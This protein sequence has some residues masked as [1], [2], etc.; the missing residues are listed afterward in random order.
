MRKGGESEPRNKGLMKM[1]NL[2]NIGERAESG[3]PYIFN[4][5]EQEGWVEPIEDRYG[6]ASRTS[7]VLSFQNK[8]AISS[9]MEDEITP[10][11][12]KEFKNGYNKIRFIRFKLYISIE[13]K[14]GDGS[15]G[16]ENM[17]AKYQAEDLIEN[18]P[19]LFK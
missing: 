7:L 10:F 17:D 14:S 4:T 3:V 1:F 13:E 5:W 18:E 16:I 11:I 15:Y 2:I 9:D 12:A 19:E 6:D 8:V